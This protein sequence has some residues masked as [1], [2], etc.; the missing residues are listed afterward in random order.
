MCVLH[1]ATTGLESGRND[2][3]GLI[4]IFAAAHFPASAHWASPL[5][6]ETTDV[7]DQN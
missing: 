7:F 5:S 2:R 4:T 1:V 6:G 3:L